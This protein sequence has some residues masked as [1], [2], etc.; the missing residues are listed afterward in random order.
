M[1]LGLARLRRLAPG[2]QTVGLSA[3]VREPLELAAYLHGRADPP[4]A[5][6]TAPEG[7]AAHITMLDTRERLPW[8][9]HSARHALGEIYAEIGKAKLA[10]LFV[11]TRFQAEQLFWDLWRINADNLPIALHHGSL[12]AGQRRRVEAAMAE[13]RLK[14]VVCT[15]TLDLG[16]DWGDVDLVINVGAPK[17]REPSDPAHRPRQP[18]A[19]RALPRDPGAGEPLRGA[20]MPRRHHGRGAGRAGYAGAAHGGP[21]T[22]SASMSSAWPAPSRSRPTISTTRSPTRRPYAELDRETF[23]QA[24]QFVAHG[25]YALRAYDRFAKIRQGQDGAW[26]ISNEQVAQQYRLNVG[27]IV[28]ASMLKV[29]LVRSRGASA[30]AGSGS[31]GPIGRGG[32]V[33]GQIEDGLSRDAAAGR[34]L[35]VR[36]RDPGAPGDRRRRG[37]LRPGRRHRA[38][39]PL[40]RGLEVPA[41]DLS[42]RAGPG[43]DGGSRSL[44]PARPGRGL[45]RAAEGEIGAAGTRR[46][47]GRDVS[48]G[49]GSTSSL[50]MPL[51]GGSPYQSLGML[52]T[53]RMERAKLRPAGFVANDYA[54]A[55][56]CRTD[57]SARLA[58]GL[59]S[60]DELFAQ[61]MM[62]DDLEDWLD[63]SSL[64]KRTFRITATIAGL[65]ERRHP[66]REKTGR[67]MTV[68]TNLVYDV[69][70]R[71]RARPH[72]APRRPRGCGHRVIGSE[73]TR[74][75]PVAHP[76]AGSCTSR[77]GRSRRSRFRSCWRSAASPSTAKRRTRSWPKPPTC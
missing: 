17:G 14:A 27:T 73:A 46:H 70:R 28:E 57:L 55:V 4:A 69:L 59:V 66:G 35:P 21:S 6:V 61:D 12:D 1:A 20:G 15:A 64:M 36:R 38:Q 30:E 32:R 31:T 63:E 22:C 50:P 16:I 25:G 74:R 3:T 24:I 60:L 7:A 26:R 72:P 23:D 47:A 48:A 40:L 51:R 62:G 10:L 11:N 65:I 29:R 8:A 39:D 71:P 75:A 5:I 68:S 53:R 9:G 34:H 43:D 54:I 18:P 49:W 45:A 44:R 13:G 76:G 77:S 37:A 42:R 33:L 19:R 52:L 67:Q 58:R 56:W 2:V 41:L